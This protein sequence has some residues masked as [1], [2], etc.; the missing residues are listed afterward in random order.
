MDP[1]QAS[2]EE[3]YLMYQRVKTYSADPIGMGLLFSLTLATGWLC[4]FFWPRA[5]LRP[6]SSSGAW[7]GLVQAAIYTGLTFYTSYQVLIT[8]KIKCLRKA[9]RCP[10]SFY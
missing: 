2:I 9:R 8:G 7:L 10:H 4:Q 3:L 6:R 1:T 5:K